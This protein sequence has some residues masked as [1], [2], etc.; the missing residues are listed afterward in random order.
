M[1]KYCEAHRH[2]TVERNYIGGTRHRES[3]GEIHPDVIMHVIWWYITLQ[4]SSFKII[5][6][7]GILTPTSYSSGKENSKTSFF[8]N[9]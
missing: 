9:F 6:R 7:E 5:W 3:A 8:V 1:V 2:N 4:E